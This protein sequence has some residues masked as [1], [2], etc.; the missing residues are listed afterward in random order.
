M[1]PITTT[2][3]L[4]VGASQPEIIMKIPV[5]TSTFHGT[6]LDLDPGPV[7]IAGWV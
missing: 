4:G 3:P 1:Q 6:D 5:L 2:T 7:V